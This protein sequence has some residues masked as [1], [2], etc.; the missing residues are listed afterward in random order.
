LIHGDFNEFNLLI[1]DN[2]RLFMIDFPQMV[3]TTHINAKMYFDRDVTC[4][5]VFFERRFGFVS[6]AY[7]VF[8]EDAA[9]LFDLDVVVAASGFTAEHNREYE[10]VR[11][12]CVLRGFARLAPTAYAFVCS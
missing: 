4:I 8:E 7:P 2:E 1:D 5:R 10:Q 6:D 11:E 3:S 12:R 9:R